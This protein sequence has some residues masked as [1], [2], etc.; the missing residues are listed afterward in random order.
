VLLIMLAVGSFLAWHWKQ[1]GSVYPWVS[2]PS[3]TL[4]P[5]ASGTKPVPEAAPENAQSPPATPD[6]KSSPAAD[7]QVKPPG[8]DAKAVTPPAAPAS[9]GQ[10]APPPASTADSGTVQNDDSTNAKSSQSSNAGSAPAPLPAASSQPSSSSKGAA[11]ETSTDRTAAAAKKS[12]AAEDESPSKKVSKPSPPAPEATAENQDKDKGEPLFI[13]G[14]RY[15]YGTGVR[16]NC[17][18]AQKSLI[19]AAEN[20]NIQAQ[21]TLATMYATGHCV[22]RSLPLAYRWFA[23]ASHLEPSNSRIEQD[24][25]ILWKQMTPEEKQIAIKSR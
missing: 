1:T 8:A 13:Q 5:E 9:P 6:A 22:P 17:D 18:L 11:E 25:E 14:Q 23:K 12:A 15:L 4:S 16:Q 7:T 10:S 24:L 2:S 3:G 21:S 20:S 19:M